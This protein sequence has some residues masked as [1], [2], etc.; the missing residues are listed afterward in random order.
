MALAALALAVTP[1]FAGEEPDPTAAPPAAPA[2][3]PAPTPTPAP[4]PAPAV[5]VVHGS[6]KL[7]TSQCSPANRAK[8][9]VS[10]TSIASVAFFV[11]GKKVKTVSSPDSSGDFTF[12]M[13]C[14]NLSVGTHRAKAAVTFQSGATPAHRTMLFQITR[15]KAAIPQ[16]AG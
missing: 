15:A 12:T 6:A 10:G 5:P 9:S 1:A 4:A 3:A 16:F 13:S 2:P 14:S 7:R 11:D 8:A